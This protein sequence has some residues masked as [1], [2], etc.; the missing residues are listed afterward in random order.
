MVYI[1]VF[2]EF[3]IFSASSLNLRFYISGL[4]LA[5]F[6]SSYSPNNQILKRFIKSNFIFFLLSLR[7][8]ED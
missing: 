5:A 8:N 4:L 2:K 1:S 3:V 6:P 7:S